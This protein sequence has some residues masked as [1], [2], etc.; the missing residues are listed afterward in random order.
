MP[1]YFFNIRTD[2]EALLDEEGI[3]FASSIHAAEEARLAAREMAA[4]AVLR[5]EPVDGTRIDVMDEDGNLI[6]SV[7]LANMLKI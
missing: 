3:S 1:K 2:Q 5:E 7:L 4:E 6:A